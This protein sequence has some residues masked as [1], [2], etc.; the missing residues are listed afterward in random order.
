[1]P[2][3]NHLPVRDVGSLAKFDP[4]LLCGDDGHIDRHGSQK[5]TSLQIVMVR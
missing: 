2:R 4:V 5:V 1:M 3:N